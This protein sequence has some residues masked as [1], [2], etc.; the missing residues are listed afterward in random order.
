M[1]PA[2]SARSA[3]CGP[4]FSMP[5]IKDVTKR[6]MNPQRECGLFASSINSDN[7]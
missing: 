1:W 2:V 3:D 7:C 5:L 4:P 6:F